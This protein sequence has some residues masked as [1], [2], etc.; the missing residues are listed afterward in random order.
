MKT[1]CSS[2]CSSQVL[3]FLKTH[4][5]CFQSTYLSHP[6][7]PSHTE[8][9][10][11]GLYTYSK[12]PLSSAQYSESSVCD[13]RYRTSPKKGSKSDQ[14]A[15][16]STPPAVSIKLGLQ[17]SKC[18]SS[19][20]SRTSPSL[21]CPWCLS[22]YLRRFLSFETHTIDSLSQETG[23]EFVCLR[24]LFSAVLKGLMLS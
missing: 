17:G 8:L 3:T 18:S 14:R 22:V 2:R 13:W 11:N 21:S 5:F 15:S 12:W 19:G 7:S 4:A 23:G 24:G 9:K 16:T 20:A 6:S 10:S 1:F